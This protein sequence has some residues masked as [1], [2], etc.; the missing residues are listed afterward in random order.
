M[1]NLTP[2]Q[3]LIALANL[4][5]FGLMFVLMHYFELMGADPAY[6]DA[7]TVQNIKYINMVTEPMGLTIDP[8]SQAKVSTVWYAVCLGIAFMF[9]GISIMFANRRSDEFYEVTN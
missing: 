3:I 7:G 1:K 6:F 8:A 4:G 2:L 5:V 9:T